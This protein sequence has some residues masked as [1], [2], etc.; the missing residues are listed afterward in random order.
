[1]KSYRNAV[2][3]LLGI[4][5]VWPAIVAA[6]SNQTLL[7]ELL[8]RIEL[9]E[10]EVREL[11]GELEIY[12]YQHSSGSSAEMT[13]L[14]DRVAALE[15]KQTTE[16]EPVYTPPPEPTYIPL[17]SPE[18]AATMPTPEPPPPSRDSEPVFSSPPTGNEQ[19][20][21][22][23]A[24]AALREGA[25]QDAIADF[26]RFLAEY[27][28]SSLSSEAYYWLG[29]SYYVTRN[30]EQARQ[31]LLTLGARYPDSNKVP[32]TLLKLGYIYSE[33]GD[34]TKSREVLEKL[35]ASYPDSLPADLAQRHLR[36]LR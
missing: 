28:N 18:P 5:L 35:V 12:Q 31:T 34:N 2:I 7:Y 6:Q 19:D 1:M 29:E 15:R 22:N 3:I 32:D 33:L 4:L 23:Q 27:P 20:T 8:N 13:A 17:P 14:L 16:P 24:F 30:F 25:Y 26:Q 21:Y 36:V 11:R 10:R 9:L